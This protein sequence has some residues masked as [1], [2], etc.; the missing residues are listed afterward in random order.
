MP[1][2]TFTLSDFGLDSLA[3]K[4]PTVK[5]VPSGAGVHGT[6][7]FTSTPVLA[8][9]TGSNGTVTLSETDG[10]VPAVWYTIQIEHLKTGGEYTHF[11]VV[12]LRIF[13]PPGYSGPISEL[14]GLP[15]SAATVLVSLDP[16]PPGYKGWYLNA[17]GPCLPPGD[18]DNPASSGTGILEIVS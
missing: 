17:P 7:L 16:P 4:S 3:S 14:P 13:V 2:I 12:G 6:R 10:V 18:P 8:T 15:L 9:L 5:F 11:D 1:T